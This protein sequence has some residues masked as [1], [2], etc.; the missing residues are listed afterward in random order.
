MFVDSHAHLDSA[1]F[2]ADRASLLERARSSQVE[3]VLAIGSGTGPGSLDCAIRLAEQ[4]HDLDA[5]IGIHPH[6]SGLA[7]DEDFRFLEDLA[8]HPKVVAWGEIGLDFHYD[9]SPRDAQI[10][11]FRRQLLL[12]KQH[13]LPVVIHTREAEAE[14]L[15]IL[16][17]HW[18][19]SG[20]EG[21]LHCYSGS[22]ELARAGLDMGFLV[23]FSGMI[24]FPK[25]QNVRN[26][27][28]RVPLDRLLIETDSPFLAPVPY[29][30]KRNEPAYVVETAK[31]LADL[32]KSTVD[33]IGEATTSNY[34]R[35]V[36]MTRSR[37]LG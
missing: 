35:F 34:Y 30:G 23:S 28:A 5:S 6:E 29:R 24:T 19:D 15:Q 36:S 4:F 33:S 14:T 18:S 9:H 20:L 37:S 2:D 31:A 32:R 3:R 26:V 7:T 11:V 10:N 8:K 13:R 12:A 27:A 22:W 17:E 25:A 21:I 1:D 16:A